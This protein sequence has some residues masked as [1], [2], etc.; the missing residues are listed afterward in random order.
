MYC[1]YLFYYYYDYKKYK[2][3]KV[4]LRK[5]SRGFTKT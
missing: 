5:L 4:P 1:F 3:N 2:Y